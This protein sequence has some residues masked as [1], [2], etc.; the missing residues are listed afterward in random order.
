VAV[1]ATPRTVLSIAGSDSG[2]GAG[3]QADGKVFS[4]L[5][6]YGTFAVTAVTAQNTVGVDAVS[7][8]AP[9]HVAAQIRAVVR[10]IGVDAVKVGMLADAACA[11]EVGRCLAE[12]PAGVP[13]VV[14]PVCASSTGTALLSREGIPELVETILAQATFVTPNL[15][16]ARLLAA[17]AGD[18]DPASMTPAELAASIGRLGPS[19]VIVTGG[20]GPGCL[21][22]FWDGTQTVEIRGQRQSTAAWHGS[23]C[24]HS[25]A[26]AAL[27]ALDE[28]P[29]KAARAAQALAAESVRAGFASLGSGPGPVNVFGKHFGAL[30]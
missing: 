19:Y 4:R 11:R 1:H 28:E 14:D 21:D 18:R 5:G 9:D 30:R 16:E 7:A 20:H 27:L 24:T 17:Y 22:V 6:V 25:A 3:I 2:G 26:L 12:L 8:V 15:D 13:I 10:D 29:L 23:G